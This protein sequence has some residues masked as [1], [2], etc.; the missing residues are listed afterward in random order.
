MIN[1]DA[2]YCRDQFSIEVSTNEPRVGESSFYPY[3]DL[4]FIKSFCRVTIGES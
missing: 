3:V 2:I 4:D 1:S